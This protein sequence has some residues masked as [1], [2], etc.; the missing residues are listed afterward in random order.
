MINEVVI[1]IVTSGS[2]VC[3]QKPQ[4]RSSRTSR[5]GP[6]HGGYSWVPCAFPTETKLHGPSSSVAIQVIAN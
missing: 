5:D 2:C 6:A 1:L 4:P 3:N